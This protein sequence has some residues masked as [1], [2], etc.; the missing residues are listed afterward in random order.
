[1]Q[2]P[3]ASGLG[4]AV[5]LGLI[6]G[7]GDDDPSA[8][9]TYATWLALVLAAYVGA[10][11]MA[12]PDWYPVLRGTIV[13]TIRTDREFPPSRYS[14]H[15]PDWSGAGLDNAI[16]TKMIG[17]QGRLTFMSSDDGSRAVRST[18]SV[19]P[20]PIVHGISRIGTHESSINVAT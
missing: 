3:S 4:R 17:R 1:M 7:D 12:Q 19:R 2:R 8:I 9:G 20:P 15:P 11:F 5:G 14:A 13:P 16:P 18:Q 6:A 10:A